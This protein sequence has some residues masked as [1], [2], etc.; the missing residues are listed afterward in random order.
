MKLGMYSKKNG[1]RCA[2]PGKGR[3]HLP[4]MAR[5]LYHY[6][7]PLESYVVPAGTL[8]WHGGELPLKEFQARDLVLF[9]GPELIVKEL[10]D[11]LLIAVHPD[12]LGLT[13]G[14]GGWKARL[15]R[16]HFGPATKVGELL[17]GPDY[18]DPAV[19]SSLGGRTTG[20]GGRFSFVPWWRRAEAERILGPLRPASARCGKYGWRS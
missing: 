4:A 13:V 20:P 1:G 10:P 15:L 18:A 14:H 9:L 19:V 11:G 12:R 8:C 5:W 3:C 6:G 2:Q 17:Q 7:R 16:E